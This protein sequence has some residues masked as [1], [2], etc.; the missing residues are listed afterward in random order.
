MSSSHPLGPHFNSKNALNYQY[1]DF[2][3]VSDDILFFSKLLKTNLF[4][5]YHYIPE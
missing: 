5:V 3:L 2:K 4:E 1:F